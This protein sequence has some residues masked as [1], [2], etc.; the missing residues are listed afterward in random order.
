M[1][2]ITYHLL[3]QLTALSMI[4]LDGHYRTVKGFE[5]LIE[6]EWCSFGHKFAQRIGHGDDKHADP[7]RSP[8]FLQFIDS[9][10]QIMKQFPNAFEFNEHFLITILDHIYSCLF[11]TFLCNS[12]MQRCK[13][14]I[15]NKTKSLWSLI[16]THLD[17]FL[18][19]LFSNQTLSHVLFPVASLRRMQLWTAYYCR[20]NPCLRIQEPLGYRNKELLLMKQELHKRVDDLQKELQL[21]LSRAVGG[22][23]SNVGGP[24]PST[25]PNSNAGMNS[26]S[27]GL[28]RL[29]SVITH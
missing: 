5:V 28:S 13:E 9:V 22:N 2:T 25:G 4:M 7:D 3:A 21:K 15:K 19:P 1:T 8:V 27:S 10:W 20:W 23:T 26:S 14:E 6:K 24:G 17:D 12:E 18:N 16:E 11:G 29:T